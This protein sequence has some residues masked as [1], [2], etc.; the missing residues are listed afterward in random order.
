LKKLCLKHKNN[1]DLCQGFSADEKEKVELSA[2][3]V[4]M[5]TEQEITDILLDKLKSENADCSNFITADKD[6][7]AEKLIEKKEVK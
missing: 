4:S 1:I 3:L 6:W 2:F 5:F 7:F